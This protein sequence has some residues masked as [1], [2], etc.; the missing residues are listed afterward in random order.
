M[1]LSEAYELIENTYAAIETRI[2]WDRSSCYWLVSP[3]NLAHIIHMPLWSYPSKTFP[4][5][6]ISMLYAAQLM[7]SGENDSA[8]I[9]SIAVH[10]TPHDVTMKKYITTCRF[11]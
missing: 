1:E 3:I 9:S 6:Y 7:L 5:Y 8:V 2:F 4:A 11:L 10:F